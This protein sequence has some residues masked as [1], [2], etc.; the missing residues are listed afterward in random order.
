MHRIKALTRQFLHA[1]DAA[2]VTEYG[3]LI[4]VVVIGMAG[5]LYIYRNNIGNWFNNI[6]NNLNN[7]S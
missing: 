1:D 5:M 7:I 2:V 4:V 6:T 3:M